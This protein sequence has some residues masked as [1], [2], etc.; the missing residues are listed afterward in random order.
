MQKLNQT[1]NKKTV[2][3]TY[4]L[5]VTAVVIIFPPEMHKK[6]NKIHAR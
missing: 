4:H 5:I 6:I 2:T 1:Q 3:Y